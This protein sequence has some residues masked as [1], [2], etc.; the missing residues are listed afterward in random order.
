[1]KSNILKGSTLFII[2]LSLLFSCTQVQKPPLEELKLIGMK[3]K[4]NSHV[5]YLYQNKIY[6]S[7][8]GDTILRYG[9]MYFEH[10]PSDSLLGLKFYHK[11]NTSECFYNGDYII[12]MLPKDS[13]AY[14]KPLCDYK[15]RHMTVYPFLE[16]SYGAI[17]LFL[18]DTLLNSHIDSL[19]RRDTT[20]NDNPCS[21]FCFWADNIL[22]DTHKKTKK[23]RK[24]IKLIVR[25]SDYLPVF[26]SQYQ[27][28]RRK[29]HTDFHYYEVVFSD[30]SFDV[31]YPQTMFSIENVP[32]Y[33][34]WDKLKAYMKLL[35]NDIYA[36]DWRLPQ[37]SGDTITLSSLK[38]KVVLLD[39][40]FIG[41]GPCI[42]SVPSLNVLQSKFKDDGFV[43]VG[44]NC[45]SDKEEK[46]KEYCTNTEMKY[47]NVWKGETIC[48]D[49]KVNAAP[50]F[51]LINR[52]GTIIYSQIGHD[53]IAL[54]KAVRDAIND[55]HPN[56]SYN[57]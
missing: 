3:M 7:Y 8:S 52:E 38:G 5:E 11:S 9:K 34:K 1:M 19:V 31:Q 50:I 44:I 47:R 14:K 15:D 29:T 26:Y 56:K 36:P 41:C 2:V 45:F 40:W 13:A 12:N 54:T 57:Q 17:Q 21:S 28:I 18:T 4:Q 24:K 53:S 49:Y 39:F 43:V 25:K 10:N 27:P 23:G 42:E 48:K 55:T 22:I 6:R 33:Y 35:P 51:Y 37:L 32:G 46:I 30:Y 16:L 20:V